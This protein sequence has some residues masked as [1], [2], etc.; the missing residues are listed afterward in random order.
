LVKWISLTQAGYRKIARPWAAA[1]E[2]TL[3]GEGSPQVVVEAPSPET[4]PA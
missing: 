3:T 2:R 4:A 1:I